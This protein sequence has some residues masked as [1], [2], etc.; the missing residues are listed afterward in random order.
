MLA[1]NNLHVRYGP[2]QAVRGVCFTVK[3]GQI[4]SLIGANGAGKTSTLLALSGLVPV[5]EGSLIFDGKDLTNASPSTIVRAGISQ[6]PEGRAV[7]APLSVQENL[8]LGAWVRH[9]GHEIRRDL[10]HIYTLFPRLAERRKQAGGQLSGGEQ[11]MLVLGRALM[12]RPRLLVLDEPSMGLA[13]IIVASVF[14][15]LAD[16][17]QQG[18]TILLVEQNARQA[19]KISHHAYVVDHGTIVR[20]GR[21]PEL[22]ADPQ[23]AETYLGGTIKNAAR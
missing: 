5:A 6:V 21:G 2:V 23:L 15:V 18:T 17:N 14:K 20:E 13:P 11:Q 1:V 7:L 8:E 16:W 4:V 19:L 9:D 10:D 12:S 22:A 3:E